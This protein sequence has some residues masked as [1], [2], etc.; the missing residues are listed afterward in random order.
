MVDLSKYRPGVGLMLLNKNKQIFVGDRIN[1][2]QPSWQMPQGGIDE[3]ESAHQALM[4]E[5]LEE[6]GCDKIKIICEAPTWL[7]YDLPK[8]TSYIDIW[9]GKYL[10]QRQ[11]WFLCEFAG[12]DNDICLNTHTPEFSSWKWVEKDELPQ[13][14]IHFK[15]QL[16]LDII[17]IFKDHL[18]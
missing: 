2:D 16:Y 12:E 18:G 15:K 3:G 14:I 4:R 7:H 17:E 8:D 9:E 10:G 11:K 6:I 1:E 5:A 13:L